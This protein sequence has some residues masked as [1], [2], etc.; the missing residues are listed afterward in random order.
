M[1]EEDK[2]TYQKTME[3][4]LAHLGAK[5]DQLKE[6]ADKAGEKAKN[7][8]SRLVHDLRQ[9]QEEAR[10]TF[11]EVKGAS[12]EAWVQLKGGLEK[13]AGQLKEG[14][15]QAGSKLKQAWHKEETGEGKEEEG[16]QEEKQP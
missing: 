12:G 1:E 16:K 4:R 6:G 13:A 5:L 15:D 11:Q 14:L 8:I 7:E 3:A 10:K 2:E 9:R